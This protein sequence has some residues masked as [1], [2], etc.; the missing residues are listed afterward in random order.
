MFKTGGLTEGQARDFPNK[1]IEN[2]RPEVKVASE[3][4]IAPDK[5][6]PFDPRDFIK[7]VPEW[8]N[9]DPGWSVP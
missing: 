9:L 5:D 1:G 2:P 7:R 3:P 6:I 4:R 8:E